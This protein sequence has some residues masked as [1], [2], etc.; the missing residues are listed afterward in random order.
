MTEEEL[1]E[2]R[3]W[4]GDQSTDGELNLLYER[5]GEV[6]EVVRSVLRRRLTDLITQ[7]ASINI[8]GEVGLNTAANIKALERRLEEVDEYY[9]P[10]GA[11]SFARVIP[12]PDR[13]RR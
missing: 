5:H 7:P 11:G 13:E 3:E 1:A 6:A 4:V 10:S 8:P 9:G 2:V 12:P